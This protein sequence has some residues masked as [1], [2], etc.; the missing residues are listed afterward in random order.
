MFFGESQARLFGVHHPPAVQ[1]RD[2][3]VL[4]CSPGPQE[5]NGAHRAF[6]KL[7]TLLAGNGFHAL[8]FDWRCTGDSSGE[9][10]D[11]SMAAWIED[12]RLAARALADLAGIRALLTGGM[13]LGAAVAARAC[14]AGVRA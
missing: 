10:E 8:R 13:R 4:L 9:S 2:R 14:A 7:A 3:A 12:V 11:A 5:A 6:R 1:P